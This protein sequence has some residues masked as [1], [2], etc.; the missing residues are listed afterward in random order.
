MTIE[1]EWRLFMAGLWTAAV[2]AA[3]V[4]WVLA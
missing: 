1:G 4:V 3:G 2:G